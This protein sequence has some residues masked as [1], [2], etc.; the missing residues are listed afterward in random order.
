M[1]GAVSLN[2]DG[3]AYLA[4]D[5]TN[6][7]VFVVRLDNLVQ[8]VSGDVCLD[9][10]DIGTNIDETVNKVRALGLPIHLPVVRNN[11]D[12]HVG[13]G[14]KATLAVDVL[15]TTDLVTNPGQ[16]PAL[17]ITD[18]PDRFLDKVIHLLAAVL[19]DAGGSTAHG[20][21][22]DKLVTAHGGAQ[23]AQTIGHIGRDIVSGGDGDAAARNIAGSGGSDRV[24][25]SC[26][27]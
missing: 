11:A 23:S 3:P 5:G 22:D 19:S 4:V 12:D 8:A 14:G 21:I 7:A 18:I 2:F 17:G 20:D 10:A 26:T 27:H 25:D 15:D 24:G 1:L 6:G 16:T 9:L 13:I